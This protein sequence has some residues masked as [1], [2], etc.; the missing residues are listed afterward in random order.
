[1]NSDPYK[2]G[3]IMKIKIS[4]KADVSALLDAAA[5]KKETEH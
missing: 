3:W 1:M 5:Y 4:N 2:A